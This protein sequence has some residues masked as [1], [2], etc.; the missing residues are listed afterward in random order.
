MVCRGFYQPGEVLFCEDT[1][2][3]GEETG[4]QARP[5]GLVDLLVP[6][7]IGIGTRERRQTVTLV[8]QVQGLCQVVR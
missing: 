3:S 5:E 8:H 4:L 6:V 7:V 2:D 1:V